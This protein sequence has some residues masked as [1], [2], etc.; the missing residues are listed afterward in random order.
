MNL[1]CL[2]P[3]LFGSKQCQCQLIINVIGLLLLQY[4]YLVGAEGSQS[5]TGKVKTNPWLAISIGR[6]DL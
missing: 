1:L 6:N 4:C 2:W 3:L 5:A